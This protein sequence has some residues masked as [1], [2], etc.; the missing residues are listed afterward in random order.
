MQPNMAPFAYG[1]HM[2]RSFLDEQGEPW[3]VAKD[4]CRVLLLLQCDLAGH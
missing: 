2:V 1:D 4:V 3:F